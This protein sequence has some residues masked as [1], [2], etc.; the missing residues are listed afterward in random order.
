MR[1]ADIQLDTLL[2][3]VNPEEHVPPDH[4]LRPIQ[5]M[6]NTA[7]ESLDEDFNV[8][9]S[10]LGRDSNPAEKLLR[11]QMLVA[12][13][14]IRSERQLM[15]QINYDLL[16]PWFVGFSI[17]GTTW[18]RPTF[19]KNWNRLLDREV[20]HQFLAQVLPQAEGESLLS[21]ENFGVDCTLTEAPAS[22]KKYRPKDVEGPPGDGDRNPT[23]DFH[24]GKPSRN[25]HEPKTEKE[26]CLLKKSKGAEAK[27]ACRDT[28]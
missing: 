27:L 26:A 16:F 6:I 5:E 4:P 19:I 24:G 15:E 3:T 1:G 22:L 2:S 23:V 13:Y 20:A 17:D 9:Q 12:F 14:T 7:F 10:D 25:T 8:L 21:K 28:F 11:A 18:S